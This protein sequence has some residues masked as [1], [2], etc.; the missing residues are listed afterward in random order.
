MEDKDAEKGEKVFLRWLPRFI[1]SL[2]LTHH[3]NLGTIIINS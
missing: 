2:R 1:G 3:K